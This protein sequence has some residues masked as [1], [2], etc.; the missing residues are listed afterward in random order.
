MVASGALDDGVTL[1]G[2]VKPES[3]RDVAVVTPAAGR[4]A[5][6]QGRLPRLGDRVSSGEVIA[7]LTPAAASESDRA[8]LSRDVSAAEATL[9]QARRGLSRA[10]RLVAEQ[11]AP[12]KRVEEA[13]TEVAIAESPLAAARQRLAAK[14]QSLSGATGINP[15]S[16]RIK[17]PI[18]GTIVEASLVPG[19]FVAEGA[20]L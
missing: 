19:S 17:A 9:A 18:S 2:T 13:R 11:A 1:Q 6:G 4:I 10:E 12:R 5:V 16:F 3:G 8:S 15:E 20:P 14:A 7:L